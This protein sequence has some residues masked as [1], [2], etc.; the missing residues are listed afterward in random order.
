MVIV[1]SEDIQSIKNIML[2]QA[3]NPNKLSQTL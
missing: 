1:I 3:R 2:I